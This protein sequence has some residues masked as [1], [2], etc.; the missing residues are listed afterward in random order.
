VSRRGLGV[1][2]GIAALSAGGLVAGISV[3]VIS[4]SSGMSSS[5][6]ASEQYFRTMMGSFRTNSMMMGAPGYW[7]MMGGPK[8]PGWMVGGTLPSY[9]M[10][11]D[12]NPGQVM[13]TLF[14]NA[15]GTRM[16]PGAAV[17]L[18]QAAPTGATVDANRVTFTSSEIHLVVLAGP[19]GHP[20]DTFTVAGLVNPTI[21]VPAGAEVSVEVVNADPDAAEGFVIVPRGSARSWAP[22][23]KAR[24]EFAGSALWFLGDPTGAGMHAGTIDFTASTAGSYQYLCAVPGHAQEGMV[25]DFVVAA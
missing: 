23:T 18:G 7:W 10:G 22:M 2:I 13:G 19:T 14:A 12:D 3:A 25:G 8:P 15:P 9:M 17:R 20:D 16:S 1:I 21:T 4:E 6:A 11:R 5:L 24:R